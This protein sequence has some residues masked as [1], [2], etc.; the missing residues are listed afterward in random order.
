MVSLGGLDKL[1]YKYVIVDDCWAKSRDENG[2]IQPDPDAFPDFDAMVDYIHSKGPLF[3]LYSDA[4][5]KTC[6]GRPGSLGYEETDAKSYERWK[7]DYLKYAYCFQ[8]LTS[9]RKPATL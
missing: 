9:R 3:G 6:A 8:N 2:I 5:I 1:G 4:G 7:V